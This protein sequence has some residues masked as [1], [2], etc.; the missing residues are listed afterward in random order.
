MNIEQL[1]TYCR[2]EYNAVVD[3]PFKKYPT[4]TAV[5]HQNGKWFGLIMAVP[6]T[7][8]G[9][10]GTDPIPIIN[11]KVAPELN[12]LL[13]QQPGYLPAYHMTKEHWLSVRL[14]HFADVADIADLID[15]SFEATKTSRR[16]SKSVANK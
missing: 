15:A 7:K 12:V 14:D 16:S 5:R 6:A 4:Y 3:H 10:P 11:L 13:R 9:L 1:I 2:T 8:L